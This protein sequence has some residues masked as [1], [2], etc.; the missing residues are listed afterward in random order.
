[1]ASFTLIPFQRSTQGSSMA[2]LKEIEA[3]E[4]RMNAARLALLDQI[5]LPNRNN[6]TY[7]KLVIELSESIEKYMSLIQK[8]MKKL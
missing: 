6:Q 1:M 3:A 2:T 7:K 8:R 5:D 4:K